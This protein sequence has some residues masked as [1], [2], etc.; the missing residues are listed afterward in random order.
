M[1]LGYLKYAGIGVNYLLKRTRLPAG[2]ILGF[3]IEPTNICNLSCIYCPQ[4]DKENHFINGK[5]FMKFETYRQILDNILTDFA[6]RFVSLHRDGEPLLNRELE[7]FIEYTVSKGIRTG[8]SSNCTM[9]PGERVESLLD[10]GLSFIKTDFCA[11]KEL[12]EKLRVGGEWEAV[13]EGMVKI[14]S[15]ARERGLDFQMN[16]T[17]IS[18]HGASD[19]TAR[20]NMLKI[21]EL[22]RDF[23]E[24]VSVLRVYFHNALGESKEIMTCGDS[25]D[26]KKRYTL[27]HHPW[28]HVV[29]DFRGN[30]VP[31]CRDLRS[32]YICG[33]LLQ[34]SMKDVW[35][36]GRFVA[37][38]KAL[39]DGA[40]ERINICSKCDLP[41][42]G[43][44][45][46]RSFLSKA[47]NILFSSIWKR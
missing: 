13:Y 4:S 17:D 38:R 30:V 8:M 5:G 44:Y 37:I 47:S 10:A 46:G 16:I 35:N 43:S 26:Y 23:K 12:Y 27:C 45:A 22:F 31:C 9:L 32:E 29:V 34:D 15:R 14:L 25:G 41:Y 40:P 11:G 33:N 24:N 20:S 3:T 28:V 21:K 18:T 36:S 7:R 2:R 19:E 1:N 39:A 42:R 6:P